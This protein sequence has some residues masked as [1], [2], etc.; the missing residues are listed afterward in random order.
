MIITC[1]DEVAIHDLKHFLHTHFRIMDLGYLKYFLGV[2]V[3]LSSQGISISQRKYTLDILDED[4]LLGAKP[5]KF[6]MEEHLE[7]SPT[8]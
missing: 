3:A 4:G 6:P 8:E 5:A 7:L 1:N 2:E